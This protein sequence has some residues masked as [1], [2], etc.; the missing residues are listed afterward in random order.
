MK[1][2]I[3]K[4]ENKNL[5]ISFNVEGDLES[6]DKN[7]EIMIYRIIQECLQNII[8]HAD[9]SKVDISIIHDNEEIDVTIE[10]NGVGFNT[11][12]M[13]EIEGMGMKN[14]KSRVEFL[15]WKFGY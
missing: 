8:K 4:I 6:L 15:K 11:S 9:A 13:E 14:I 3:D 7:L 12:L 5:R 2:F 1:N 10:D